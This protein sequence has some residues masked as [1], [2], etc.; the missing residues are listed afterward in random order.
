MAPGYKKNEK[1]QAGSDRLGKAVQEHVD[2]DL[3]PVLPL[4]GD[5]DVEQL[6]RRLL[7]GIGKG[8]VRPFSGQ[9]PPQERPGRH[10]A[11]ADQQGQGIDHQS[12]TQAETPQE[13][14]GQH[15]LKKE[16][17]SQQSGIEMAEERGQVGL[18]RG[19]IV[20]DGLGLPVDESGDDAGH[21]RQRGQ[22]PQVGI[23]AHGP[24]GIDEAGRTGRD[25][26]ADRRFAGGAVQPAEEDGHRQGARGQK[27]RRREKKI[28]GLVGPGQEPGQQTAGDA[29]QDSAAAEESDQPLGLARIEAVVD[30]EPELGGQH[31]HEDVGP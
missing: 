6:A 17:Q 26:R 31:D 13:A 18:G 28:L 27:G 12:G 21:D 8:L 1:E 11:R 14:A 9:G 16:G 29:A 15:E 19:D 20:D 5:G 4:G 2:E 3:G 23:A 7:D 25:R 10:A 30:Q 24:V 22:R